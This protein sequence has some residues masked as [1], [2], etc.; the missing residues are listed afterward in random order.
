MSK[1]QKFAAI[2]KEIDLTS[3]TSKPLNSNYNIAKKC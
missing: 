2:Q 3:N 1:A